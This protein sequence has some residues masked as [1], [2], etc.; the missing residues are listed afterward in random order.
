MN[1]VIDLLKNHRSIRKF[2]PESVSKE[3]LNTIIQA[4]GSAATS[5]NIQAYSVINIT[6]NDNRKKLAELAGG[7][8]W[9]EKSPVFLV[10][11]ADLKR[12]EDVCHYEQKEMAAGYTEQFIVATV[13]V[14]LAAENAMVA[15][16]SLGLGGV[17][18]GG[19]R[20]NPE[21]VCQLLKMPDYVYP[22]FGMCLGYPDE[23]PEQKPRLPVEVTLMEDYYSEDTSY[24]GKYN[25]ICRDYYQN[26]TNN[27]RYDTWTS[28]ISAMMSSPSRTHMKDFL[29][30][31][32]FGTL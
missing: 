1:Q 5:N 8:T 4:A 3:K 18:I 15:A 13:D 25:E 23:K 32:G 24:L 27:S 22:I 12:S 31:K 10:F 7:Q 2:T 28:Q 16:E 17:F 9:V 20:N 19:I 6:D 21:K 11:C 26:R 30:K 14:T 29:E